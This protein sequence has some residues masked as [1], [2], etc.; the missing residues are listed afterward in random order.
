[1]RDTGPLHRDEAAPYRIRLQGSLDTTW[2]DM[3]RGMSVAAEPSAPGA[4]V[5]ILQGEVVDQ[6]ALLGILNLVYELGLPLLSVQCL[7]H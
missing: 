4:P 1:M 3:L 6:A 5:T 7:K 2:S